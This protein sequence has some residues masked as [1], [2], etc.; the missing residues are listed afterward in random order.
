MSTGRKHNGLVE[1]DVLPS[2]YLYYTRQYC[3][4][5]QPTCFWNQYF[6]NF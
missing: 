6:A 5:I 3:S 2:E 4:R 1:C